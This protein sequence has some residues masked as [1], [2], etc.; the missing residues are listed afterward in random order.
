CSVVTVCVST[1]FFFSSRRRHTRLV[2]D[3]SSDVCSSDLHDR[4]G[5]G[6][7]EAQAADVA[8]GGVARPERRPAERAEVHPAAAAIDLA[9]AGE[10]GRAA[11]REKEEVLVGGGAI[12]KKS[13]E[14]GGM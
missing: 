2:S 1:V 11:G 3:W 12:R 10:I 13:R 7:A 14:S 6:D 9:R 8:L 4:R 5:Q